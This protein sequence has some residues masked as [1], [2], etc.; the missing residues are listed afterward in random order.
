EGDPIESSAPPLP[1][2][3]LTRRSAPSTDERRGSTLREARVPSGVA[4][5]QRPRAVATRDKQPGAESNCTSRRYAA[6]SP[7]SNGHLRSSFEGFGVLHLT[8]KDAPPA[9][10]AGAPRFPPTARSRQDPSSRPA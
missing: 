1:R 9:K 2:M 4:G 6:S 5:V 10:L 7:G 3:T 8:R